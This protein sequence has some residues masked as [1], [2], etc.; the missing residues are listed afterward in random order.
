MVETKDEAAH[1]SDAAVANF[2]DDFVIVAAHVETLARFPQRGRVEGFKAD[3][4]S[5]APAARREVEQFVIP[6]YR[7]GSQSAPTNVEGDNRREKLFCVL[8]I[9]DKVEIKKDD[10]LGFHLADVGYDVGHRLLQGPAPRCRHYAEFT[11]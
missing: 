4:Q 3:Q 7:G 11:L 5:A 6:R 2:A 8:N 9:R 1:K 10:S